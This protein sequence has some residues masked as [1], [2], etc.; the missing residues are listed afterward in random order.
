[1]VETLRGKESLLANCC[2][3]PLGPDA[4]LS[5][6]HLTEFISHGGSLSIVIQKA[7][8][9]LAQISP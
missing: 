8:N 5:D 3:D 2:A 1:M 4:R 9:P 7:I 6:L